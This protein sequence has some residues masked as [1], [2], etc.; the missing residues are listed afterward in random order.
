M[1]LLKRFSPYIIAGLIFLGLL[2]V[3]FWP[4]SVWPVFILL[5][6]LIAGLVA[7]Y[8]EKKL[9]SETLNHFIAPVFLFWSMYLFFLF[10]E[11]IYVKLFFGA[12][13]AFLFAV[14]TEQIFFKKFLLK[15]YDA[16][17]LENMSIYFSILA[18]FMGTASFFGFYI[19]LHA[20]RIL[21]SIAVVLT[22]LALNYHIFHTLKANFWESLPYVLVLTLGLFEIFYVMTFLPVSFA[23][24]GVILAALYYIALGMVRYYFVQ[25]YDAKM[26]KRHV[27]IGLIIL[28][29]VVATA[30]WT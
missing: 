12:A 18:I 28:I 25:F 10:L 21:I 6:L 26:V 23:V 14:Y 17:A 11:N 29:A 5:N 7:L 2:I 30:R 16:K 3:A 20:S 24:S 27:I 13:A 19:F 15:R 9:D 4:S 8:S 22:G 1:L